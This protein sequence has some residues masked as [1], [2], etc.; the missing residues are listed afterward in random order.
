V[1]M[2]NIVDIL[3]IL[4]LNY[5]KGTTN[6]NMSRSILTLGELLEERIIVN[7]VKTVMCIRG[8]TIRRR[9]DWMIRF[10]ALIHTTRNYR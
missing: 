10:I 2:T 1:A 8:V 3:N 6:F 9:L 5:L 4:F 7:S